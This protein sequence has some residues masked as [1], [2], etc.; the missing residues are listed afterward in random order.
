[1]SGLTDTAPKAESTPGMVPFPA[2]CGNGTQGVSEAHKP[3]GWSR[4]RHSSPK[5]SATCSASAFTPK[6]SVA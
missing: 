6:V 4:N 1:M 2:G 5:R 3:D